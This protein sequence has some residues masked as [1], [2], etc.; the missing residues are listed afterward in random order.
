[1]TTRRDLH[2]EPLSNVIPLDTPFTMFIEPTNRCNFRCAFCPTSKPNLIS[3]VN[4]PTGDMTYEFSKQII[5]QIAL[6]PKKLKMLN[7][8]YMGE[9][10]LNPHTPDMIAYAV[11]K[12][13]SNWYEIRTNG[14]LLNPKMNRRLIASGINR[15]GISVE[16]INSIGYQKI[17]GVHNFNIDR[18]MD[19]I[20]DLHDNEGDNCEVY[21]KI[22]DTGLTEEEKAMFFEL[23]SPL[24]DDI[25]IEYLIDWNRADDFDFKLGINSG[26]MMTGHDPYIKNICSY[27][28]YT[29][30][31]T[32][33]G[34]TPLCCVDWSYATSIGNVHQENMQQIWNGERL[35][36][37]R[38]MH[39]EN[40]R[41]ENPA[42]AT[43][44]GLF[45]CPDNIEDK[46]EE[47]LSRL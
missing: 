10:L 15:V 8:Q 42:C 41:S 26:K 22:D 16:A 40:R 11:D 19:N 4:R 32:W 6:F 1:M 34:E 46:R 21:I 30:G 13:I 39:L 2:R 25:Q 44:K 38:I 12:N 18:F 29:L 45:M 24:A 47:I 3:S 43:C 20:G 7:F 27:P 9:P 14:S 23:F 33:H 36:D 37:F 28:F 17:S 31:I 5:D 35:K